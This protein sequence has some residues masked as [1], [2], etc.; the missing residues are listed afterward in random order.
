MHSVGENLARVAITVIDDHCLSGEDL[1]RLA[2]ALL[3]GKGKGRRCDRSPWRNEGVRLAHLHGNSQ[4]YR[5][6]LFVPDCR[7]E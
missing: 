6:V 4:L 1:A 2:L 3:A 5:Q 7:Y